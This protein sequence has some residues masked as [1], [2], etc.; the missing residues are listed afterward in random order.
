[1]Q[2]FIISRCTDAVI[3]MHVSPKIDDIE[4]RDFSFISY[5]MSPSRRTVLFILHAK[6]TSLHTLNKRIPQKD[7]VGNN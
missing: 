6:E 3:F 4:R 1:M 7:F 2:N 5:S